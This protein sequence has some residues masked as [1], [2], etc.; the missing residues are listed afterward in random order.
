MLAVIVPAPNILQQFVP[1]NVNSNLV[2]S[3]P[4]LQLG[5]I[6]LESSTTSVVNI[7]NIGTNDITFGTALFLQSPGIAT[8]RDFS[9]SGLD[10]GST[11]PAGGNA[12]LNVTFAPVQPPLLQTNLTRSAVYTLF[13]KD[14]SAISEMVSA[15][16][17]QGSQVPTNTDTSS[18]SYTSGYNLTMGQPKYVLATL[19]SLSPPLLMSPQNNSLTLTITPPSSVFGDT[20]VGSSSGTVLIK[21]RNTSGSSQTITN[22]TYQQSSLATNVCFN[23]TGSLTGTIGAS[24]SKSILASFAPA[25]MGA[26]VAR[27]TFTQSDGSTLTESLYGNGVHNL[28][29]RL[30]W[31]PSSNPSVYG[32]NICR[33]TQDGGPYTIIASAIP[34]TNYVDYAVQSGQTYYYVAQCVNNVGPSKYSNQ[35]SGKA[36]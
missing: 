28:P 13:A 14:G 5:P 26:A 34:D 36:P 23:F 31:N 10:A 11:V 29:L 24:S 35:A 8:N 16:I 27:V 32:Y 18:Y 17:M 33:S 21:I 20:V 30:V 12:A 4:I 15:S 6:P 7:T 19:V 25:V 2:L 3:P 1:Q 22:A 9:I